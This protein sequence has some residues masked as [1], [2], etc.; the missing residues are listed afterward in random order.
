MA[1]RETALRVPGAAGSPSVRPHTIPPAE[2]FPGGAEASGLTCPNAEPAAPVLA[3]A[4]GEEGLGSGFVSC[5]SVTKSALL[6]GIQ[7]F[8]GNEKTQCYVTSS[9][10]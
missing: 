5:S 10:V 7:A 6:P 4:P 8:E 2:E 9:I 3:A 1:S